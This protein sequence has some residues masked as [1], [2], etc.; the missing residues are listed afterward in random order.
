MSSADAFFNHDNWL[1]PPFNRAAFQAVQSL[2]PTVPLSR[3]TGAI[4]PMPVALRDVSQIAYRWVDGGQRTVG[5]MLDATFTDAFV[6]LKDGVVVAE[7]CVRRSARVFSPL[8][9]PVRCASRGIARPGATLQC[10]QTETNN[11]VAPCH[12]PHSRV[13]IAMA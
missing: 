11:V 13:G 10:G 9:R 3:G 4:S 2:F 8:P 5:E 6:V 1:R 12:R 7:E